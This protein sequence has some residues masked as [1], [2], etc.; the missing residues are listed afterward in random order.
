MADKT[1]LLYL[2]DTYKFEDKAKILTIEQ[3][4]AT[5]V[6]ALDRTLFHPQGGGQPSDTGTIESLSSTAKFVVT[7]VR[8]H[9]EIERVQHGGKYEHDATSLVIGEEVKVII[10]ADKR[11]LYARLHSAGHLLD[12]CLSVV[13]EFKLIPGKG[14]H[15]PDGP[16][17][18]YTGSIPPAKREEVKSKLQAECNRL[19]LEATRQGGETVKIQEVE[20][21]RIG[22]VC[23]YVPEYLPQGKPARVVTLVVGALGCPCGGTHVKSIGEI[24][25]MKLTKMRA[26]KGVIRIGYEVS[27]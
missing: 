12:V 2:S 14:Y 27:V 25:S 22:T 24:G 23:G 10:D 6:I 13:P 1:Q 15:F 3:N 4:G 7:E 8:Y 26:R 11:R 21:D 20:Y 9:K 16:Y 5:S 18:E 17:V 19:I